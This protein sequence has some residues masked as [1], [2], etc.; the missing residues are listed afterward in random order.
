MNKFVRIYESSFGEV[1]INTSRKVALCT[2]K[3]EYIPIQEFKH[4]LTIT[5]EQVEEFDLE[6]FI[7]DNR[8]LRTF[9]QPSMEWYYVTWK[10]EMFDKGLCIHRKILPEEQWFKKCV[11]QG[12]S[13][14]LDR[15]PQTVVHLLDIRYVNSVEE[16]LES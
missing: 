11:E 12:E 14:I 2:L 8:A 3:A 6:K 4:L 10:K 16:A 5:G 9:H 15:N 7:F 13:D 1:S